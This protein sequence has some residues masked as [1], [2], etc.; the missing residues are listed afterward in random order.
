MKP[1]RGLCGCETRTVLGSRLEVDKDASDFLKPETDFGGNGI[2]VRLE[3]RVRDS[4]YW[5]CMLSARTGERVLSVAARTVLSD[6]SV[7]AWSV[8]PIPA[9]H[10]PRPRGDWN[11]DDRSDGWGEGT[12]TPSTDLVLTPTT[13]GCC[14]GDCDKRFRIMSYF[15]ALGMSSRDRRIVL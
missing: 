9:C 12:N 7:A 11:R 3:L 10:A 5:S 1:D 13:R 2:G 14:R 4:R 6:P 15:I 8:I